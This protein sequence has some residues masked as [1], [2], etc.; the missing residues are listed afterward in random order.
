[1]RILYVD[2]SLRE[3]VGHHF[4][5]SQILTRVM[6]ERGHDVTLT[7][8][9]GARGFDGV[10]CF[11]N[12]VY[13]AMRYDPTSPEGRKKLS[14]DT[15]RVTREIW[16]V[17]TQTNPDLV[18]VHSTNA[19][20]CAGIL[21]A[22]DGVFRAGSSSP[23]LVVELPYPCEDTAT[24]YYGRQLSI[25]ND[26]I[27]EGR[28]RAGQNFAPVTV[29]SETS[30]LLAEATG[31]TVGTMPSPYIG[32]ASVARH[33]S[34][35]LRIGCLGYQG[36][37]KGYHLLPGI[38]SHPDLGDLPVEFVIQ[39][40]PG[41]MD[42]ITGQLRELGRTKGKVVLIDH[43]LDGDAY[44]DLARSIDIM[45]L[46]YEPSRYVSAISG[47]AYEALSH[48]SIIVAPRDT[49]VGAIVADYQ[50]QSPLFGDWAVP[51]I[52]AALRDAV[53]DHERLASDAKDG[54]KHYLSQNGPEAYVQTLEAMSG[55]KTSAQRWRGSQAASRVLSQL[56][57]HA[58]G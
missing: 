54:A 43:S 26:M 23:S 52:V 1:M 34:G 9:R 20:V 39:T 30:R 15:R 28:W 13:P 21:T 11:K 50:P 42:E 6:R 24:N 48:G 3:T 14:R 19:P 2:V 25:L 53:L 27:A 51:S 38:V 49:T 41:N 32:R 18:Y 7:V 45:L 10:R 31:L 56:S 8:S 58:F 44:F 37:S 57:R 36:P 29:N 12:S 5:V 17:L 4:N 47:I 55:G 40:Q 16:P 33:Q 46:P 22:L 35:P